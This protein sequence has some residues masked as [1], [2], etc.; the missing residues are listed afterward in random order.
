VYRKKHAFYQN[1]L[2]EKNYLKAKEFLSKKNRLRSDLT[3]SMAAIDRAIKLGGEKKKYKNIRYQLKNAE[4]L[5]YE[6]NGNVHMA[7]RD[8]GLTK[9]A[10]GGQRKLYVWLKNV[11]NSPFYVNVE[12]FTLV[13][14]N[15]KRYKYNDC[16][17][18]LIVNL[19]PGQETGGF[20]YFYTAT[21]PAKLIFS[22]I[23]AGTV[24]R[25]FP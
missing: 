10:T 17:R 9:G 25:V 18:E 11:G 13:G 16:S 4:L 8:D 3:A 23:T 14:K 20:L 1:K 7:V 6:G 22:H 21:R 12:F 15:N 24:T 19:E 5:F 2:A